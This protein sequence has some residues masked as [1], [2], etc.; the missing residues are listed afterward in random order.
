MVEQLAE[1]K[2]GRPLDA[3]NSNNPNA[4]P[5]WGTSLVDRLNREVL[6]ALA[7]VRQ[8]LNGVVSEFNLGLVRFGKGG[9]SLGWGNGVPANLSA[10]ERG[11]Y[12]QM[13]GGVGSTFYV[14][15][16]AAWRAL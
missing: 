13:D 14:W 11:F 3:P 12:I 9:P 15:E 7:Q 6:E 10:T 5:S 8:V 1:K 16:G 2:V 4:L